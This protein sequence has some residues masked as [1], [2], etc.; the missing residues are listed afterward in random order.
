VGRCTVH[1][2]EADGRWRVWSEADGKWYG[3]FESFEEADDERQACE[4]RRQR[5]A[6][7]APQALTLAA[8][9]ERVPRSRQGKA[10]QDP[11]VPFVQQ[12][13]DGAWRAWS[14]ADG[15]FLRPWPTREEAML[16]LQQLSRGIRP[17]APEQR[18]LFGEAEAAPQGAQR[19]LF[20]N[21]TMTK[22]KSAQLALPAKRSVFDE[23]NT[24]PYYHTTPVDYVVGGRQGLLAVDFY[25]DPAG[26]P[27]V[28]VMRLRPGKYPEYLARIVFDD[29]VEAGR[30]ARGVASQID[31]HPHDVWRGGLAAIGVRT[32]PR[33]P[34]SKRGT[35][36]PRTDCNP[37]AGKPHDFIVRS[38]H[39][40]A[41]SDLQDDTHS[42]G[43]AR[44]VARHWAPSAIYRVRWHLYGSTWEAVGTPSLVARLDPEGRVV[45]GNP[46]GRRRRRNPAED[47]KFRKQLLVVRFLDNRRDA[48]W[49]QRQHEEL[50]HIE[51]SFYADEPGIPANEK[52]LLA[53]VAKHFGPDAFVIY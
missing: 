23:L 42:L 37:S 27:F 10:G 20:G 43:A 29:P 49:W 53:V 24:R 8:P 1:A 9:V 25:A 44:T 16:Q 28:A 34:R 46:A 14:P 47:A 19:S 36:R 7:P 31:D 48:R 26:R 2:S 22:K 13:S 17:A 50:G 39:P 41:P 11:S 40:D 6:T 4:G 33:L 18:G 52:E 51:T 38:W 15:K 30:Y 45:K 12:F 3:P 5:R 32:N 21:P 35:F